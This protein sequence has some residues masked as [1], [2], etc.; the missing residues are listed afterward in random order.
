MNPSPPVTNMCGM[1]VGRSDLEC[2]R[3][4]GDQFAPLLL[5]AWA[6]RLLCD[7]QGV[8]NACAN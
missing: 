6:L 2:R 8:R 3:D 5:F 1:V 7:A 4:G